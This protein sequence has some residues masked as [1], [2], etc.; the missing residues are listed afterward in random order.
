MGL[1]WKPRSIQTTL[2]NAREAKEHVELLQQDVAALSQRSER[3]AIANEALWLL[4][5]DKLGLSEEELAARIIDV[6]RA[7]GTH[8][9]LLAPGVLACSQC[10]RT[11]PA[12][13][14]QCLYCGAP[15]VPETPPPA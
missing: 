6:E 14:R 11:V 7:G 13:H 3:L 9:A 8:D 1:F 15:L 4:L 2:L 12:R 5:K 10:A